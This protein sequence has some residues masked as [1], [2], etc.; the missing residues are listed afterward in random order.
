[1]S[2]FTSRALFRNSADVNFGLSI[3]PRCFMWSTSEPSQD[4]F[5]A[6]AECQP[7]VLVPQAFGVS[8]AAAMASPVPPAAYNTGHLYL[9]IALSSRFICYNKHTTPQ[10]KACGEDRQLS[11]E[12]VSAFLKVWSS[13][14]GV[15]NAHMH[16]TQALAFYM[17]ENT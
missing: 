7:A 4:R 12:I 1:M 16:V 8:I 6:R 3:S 15:D 11:G 14:A 5:A 2:Y 9:C 10:A 17:L 13:F